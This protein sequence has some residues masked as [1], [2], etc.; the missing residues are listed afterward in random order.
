MYNERLEDLIFMVE[1]ITGL[2]HHESKQLILTTRTGKALQN[3]NQAILYEQQTENLYQIAQDLKI[4]NNFI[5][6]EAIFT[7]DSI[8]S[9]F[10]ALLKY[11]ANTNDIHEHSLLKFSGTRELKIR[12]K[13]RYMAAQKQMLQLKQQNR[14]N[15]GRM[16]SC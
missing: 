7:V 11:R 16:T 2:S 6:A 5:D 13:K 14:F 1:Q 9:A 4:Q 3:K 10:E 12:Q 15:I 8:V